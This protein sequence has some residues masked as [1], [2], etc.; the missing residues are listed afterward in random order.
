MQL[1]GTGTQCESNRERERAKNKGYK[2]AAGTSLSVQWLRLGLLMHGV[3]GLI[4]DW[5][6]K[7]SH[8]WQS[9]K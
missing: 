9:K 3:A 4:P 5:G 2:Q 8:A 7:I 6:A 1:N